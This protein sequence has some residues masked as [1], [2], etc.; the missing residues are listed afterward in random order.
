MKGRIVNSQTGVDH[1]A[2][3]TILAD[4]GR[5]EEAEQLLR[6]ALAGLEAEANGS[7]LMAA[8]AAQ[9]A[10]LL[11]ATGRPAEAMGL[12]ER[13]LEVRRRLLEPDHP[14]VAATLHNLAVVCDGAGR[15]DR[16]RS[17]WAELRSRSFDHQSNTT[18]LVNETQR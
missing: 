15:P 2:E 11:G 12:Y 5:Y 18:H 16:A 6:D 3:A 14:T 8:A 9:L 1:L 13:S 7:L 4:D 17:V 10:G